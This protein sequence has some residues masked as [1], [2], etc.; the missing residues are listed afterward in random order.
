MSLLIY[1]DGVFKGHR[2]DPRPDPSED[3]DGRYPIAAD[4][5]RAQQDEDVV[6]LPLLV[7]HYVSGDEALGG[8]GES[9]WLDLGA[10]SESIRI[11]HLQQVGIEMQPQVEAIEVRDLLD[12]DGHGDHLSHPDLLAGG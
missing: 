2:T 5:R 3:D 6:D 9:A 1:Q 4:G 10:W 8:I 12:A 11:L 7:I